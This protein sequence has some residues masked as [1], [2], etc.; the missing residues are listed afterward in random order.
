VTQ[1]NP[2]GPH[3]VEDDILRAVIDDTALSELQQVHLAQCSRCRSLREQLEKELTRLGQLAKRYSPAPQKRITFV[4]R[5]ARS[6]FFKWGFAF[7]A[8]AAILGVA[9]ALAFVPPWAAL[10]IGAAAGLLVPLVTF[11]VQYLLRIEDPTGAVPVA[12][13]ILAIKASLAIRT[14]IE[15]RAGMTAGIEGTLA[16]HTIGSVWL[17]GCLLYLH[18]WG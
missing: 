1:V 10:A 14:G 9:A 15:D 4:E 13:L 11:A 12:L 5:K 18:W 16:I 8:A 6:P 7:S 17:A 2:N 3:L